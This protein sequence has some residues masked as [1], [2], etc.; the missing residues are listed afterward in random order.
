MR[1]FDENNKSFEW[2]IVAAVFASAIYI[3]SFCSKR[4]QA[5][6]DEDCNL[7]LVDFSTGVIRSFYKPLIIWDKKLNNDVRYSNEVDEARDASHFCGE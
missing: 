5:S 4:V 1:F 2:T 6:S 7:R 3:G